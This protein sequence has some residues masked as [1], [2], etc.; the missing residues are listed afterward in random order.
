KR[1]VS[2][3]TDKC[4]KAG[5]DLGVRFQIVP[6]WTA[7]HV[8]VCGFP[9]LGI[10]KKCSPGMGHSTANSVEVKADSHS[11]VHEHSCRLVE[12]KPTRSRFMKHTL[13]HQVAH[14]AVQDIG[15]TTRS[16]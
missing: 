2:L 7:K 11:R 12:F 3:R 6:E 4:I 8:L 13:P 5:R 16:F 14:Y 9:C 10:L 1:S 15:I